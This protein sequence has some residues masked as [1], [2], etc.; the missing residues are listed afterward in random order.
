LD[1]TRKNI[2]IQKAEIE[3][4]IV[5]RYNIM[6]AFKIPIYLYSLHAKMDVILEQR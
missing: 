1:E 4:K 5:M 2:E 3:I 6:L